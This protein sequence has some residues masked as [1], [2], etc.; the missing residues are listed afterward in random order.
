M[1]P[2]N[3][4]AGLFDP[5]IFLELGRLGIPADPNVTI[6]WNGTVDDLSST[7]SEVQNKRRS[8]NLS[9]RSVT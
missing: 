4:E 5:L 3:H 8:P 1:Q 2:G 7:Y 6:P 9:L